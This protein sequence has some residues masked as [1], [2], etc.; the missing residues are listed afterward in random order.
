MTWS[1][2]DLV[3][4]KYPGLLHSGYIRYTILSVFMQRCTPKIFGKLGH[5]TKCSKRIRY[6]TEAGDDSFYKA[7]CI[8]CV[9]GSA[10]IN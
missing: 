5:V 2:N 4:K 1:L 7:T 10:Q 6:D 9:R 3:S 8:L